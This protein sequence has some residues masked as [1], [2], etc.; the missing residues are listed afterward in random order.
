V[1]QYRVLARKYRPRHFGELIGQEALVRTLSNAIQSGRVAH[2]FMLTGVRGVGKTT[3][4]RIIARALNYTGP[5]GNS[6]PTTGPTDDCS[7]AQAIAEDRHP[8]VLEMDA[9]SRTGVNDIRELLDSVRYAP[10][11]ARYKIYIIDEVHMLST[12]AFNALLKTLEEPPPHVK[13]IFATTEIRKVPITILSRCQRFDLR[14]VDVPTLT[15]HYTE[16]CRKEEITADADAIALI[17]R[18]ADGSVRDGLSLLDQA[19]A[20]GDGTV[21]LSAVQ[22][23]LGLADRGASFR[24]LRALLEGKTTEALSYATDMQ[25]RGN[26]PIT[27][28]EDLLDHTHLLTRMKAAPNSAGDLAGNLNPE[29]AVEARELSQ[30]LSMPTLNR[31]WQLLLKG[32]SE[33][34]YAPDP[35]AALD[36]VL[37]R[38]TYA[39]D[40]PDPA[41]LLRQLENG[42]VVSARAPREVPSQPSAPAAQA[43][44]S[45]GGGASVAQIR[46]AVQPGVAPVAN[47][48]LDTLEDVVSLLENNG[49]MILASQVRQYVRL[50]T[51]Q[52]L[53]LEC[54][55]AQGAPT[56]LAGSLQR[57]LSDLT[58]NRFH[59]ILG[60]GEAQPSLDEQAK[61][62]AQA[63]EQRMLADPRAVA[64][65]ET[66]PGTKLIDIKPATTN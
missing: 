38:M 10:V 33:I 40:L 24:L 28:A 12:S 45:S 57:K 63:L 36:I 34:Q 55:L 7:V 20:M 16:I 14:R 37:I 6:G 39:A 3:T 66:F 19:I 51:L 4:A 41:D 32:A 1:S 8:D 64:L 5:D 2:A 52:P 35:A 53:K 50:I 42:A 31:A 62:A 59:V 54:T 18:A 58:G 61:A 43:S 48:N 46:P 25:M 60:Q 11:E 9:A 49:A 29:I 26:D 23:M 13:F 21:A 47:G 65:A 56:E 44:I 22:E 15:A 27:I 30:S 17:A